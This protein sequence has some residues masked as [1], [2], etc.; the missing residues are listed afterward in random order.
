VTAA[1]IL[2]LGF[3]D[4]RRTC[5]RRLKRAEAHKMGNQELLGH[6]KIQTTRGCILIGLDELRRAVNLLPCTTDA[7]E[8]A[9]SENAVGIPR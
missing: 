1:A 8:P 9:T 4:L 7:Q 2:P 3:D 5:S 6:R